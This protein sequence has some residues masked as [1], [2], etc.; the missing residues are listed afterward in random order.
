MSDRNTTPLPNRSSKPRDPCRHHCTGHNVFQLLSEIAPTLARHC[1][2][3]EPLN[4]AMLVINT[5][6]YVC[7][8][9]FTELVSKIFGL[10]HDIHELGKEAR[11]MERSVKR[12]RH[13][14]DRVGW[15]EGL[16]EAEAQIESMARAFMR[17][18]EDNMGIVEAH[19]EKLYAYWQGDAVQGVAREFRVQESDRNPDEESYWKGD[20]YYRNL[21]GALN[22]FE[23]YCMYATRE[24]IAQALDDLA[25]SLQRLKLPEIPL[26]PTQEGRPRRLGINFAL[27]LTNLRD[28]YAQL[29]ADPHA[30]C[31]LESHFHIEAKYWDQFMS[32][33]HTQDF[34]L[35]GTLL[36]WR[37]RDLAC[38]RAG[39]PPPE[40][41]C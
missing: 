29:H 1:P 9:P 36:Q 41:P 19:N 15:S 37:A 4:R 31:P 21:L 25:A 8:P 24:Q 20:D 27:Q 28:T 6:P 33:V 2:N 16:A 23:A 7:S 5:R 40:F 13:E 32:S 30:H 39:Q 10:A 3:M 22:R 38:R 35:V 26:R 18:V 14:V 34:F 11:L 12:A 17:T